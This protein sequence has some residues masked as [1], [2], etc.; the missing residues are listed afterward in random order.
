SH[1]AGADFGGVDVA[2]DEQDGLVAV[3]QG[4]GF[5]VGQVARIS[6]AAL[7]LAIA[8]EVVERFGRADGDGDE[9]GPVGGL[10]ELVDAQTGGRGRGQAHVF[11][12]AVPAQELFLG[13]H[14]ESGELLGGGEGGAGEGGDEE[15]NG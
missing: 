4:F 8:G 7:D 6:E 15:Q 11:D 10:A 9:G 14:A 2:G 5:G 3:E 1:L 12:N 13:A